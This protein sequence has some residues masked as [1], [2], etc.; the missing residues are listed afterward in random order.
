MQVSWAADHRIIDGVTMAKFSN[1][2]KYYL[3]QPNIL[4]LN[5]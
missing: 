5:I 3:E 2:F 4:L 1:L